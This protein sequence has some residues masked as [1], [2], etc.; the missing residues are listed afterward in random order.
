[1]PENPCCELPGMFQVFQVC[2]STLRGTCLATTA[3]IVVSMCLCMRKHCICMNLC[4]HLHMCIFV[5][6]SQ[7]LGTCILVVMSQCMWAHDAWVHQSDGMSLTRPG[8]AVC[9]FTEMR[10]SREPWRNTCV[11]RGLECQG[12]W[13]HGFAGVTYGH[14]GFC[15]INKTYS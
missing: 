14:A 1:M 4:M 7:I 13:S 9:V 12:Q 10:F 15:F 3:Y 11:A 8:G 2:S 6:A 5:N